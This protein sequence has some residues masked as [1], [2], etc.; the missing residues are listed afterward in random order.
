MEERKVLEAYGCSN[1]S[2]VLRSQIELTYRQLEKRIEE[3]SIEK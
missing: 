3:A 2:E 1:T